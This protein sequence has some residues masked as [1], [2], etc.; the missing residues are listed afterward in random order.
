[1]N[2]PKTYA[3]TRICRPENKHWR[4]FLRAYALT[5]L[6]RVGVRV[7]ARETSHGTSIHVP[8]RRA[9]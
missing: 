9:A 5:R 4:G 2:R 8:Y 3:L 6:S 7:G 1:M